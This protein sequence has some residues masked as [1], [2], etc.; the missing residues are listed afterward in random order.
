MLTMLQRLSRVS[1]ELT[2]DTNL[3]DKCYGDLNELKDAFDRGELTEE[4]VTLR[5]VYA[6]A[7][8]IHGLLVVDGIANKLSMDR[9]KTA[10]NRNKDEKWV[11]DTV[12]DVTSGR[13]DVTYGANDPLIEAF[14]DAIGD[15]GEDVYVD[16]SQKEVDRI[17]IAYTADMVRTG[18]TWDRG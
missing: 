16:V 10:R 1:S 12:W 13:I 15:V 7:A 4:F 11:S 2:H 6:E 14:S 3:E 9:L 18:L 8:Y 5:L 17:L